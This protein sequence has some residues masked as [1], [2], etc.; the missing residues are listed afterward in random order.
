VVL[1][2]NGSIVAEVRKLGGESAKLRRGWGRLQ[3]HLSRQALGR[4]L[5]EKSKK[6]DKHT[7]IHE[8]GHAVAHCRLNIQQAYVSIDREEIYDEEGNLLAVKRGRAIAEG[9]EHVCDQVQAGDQVLAYYAGFAALLAGGYSEKEAVLGADDDFA[10]ADYLIDFW[11]IGKDYEWKQKA[12][13][14]M[15]DE[16]NVAAV[17]R[18]SEELLRERRLVMDQ[19]ETLIDVADGGIP[20]REYQRVKKAF[21][22][23]RR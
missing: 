4:Q 8:A 22:S 16:S 2:L 20:E 6:Q 5:V 21:W 10:L 23:R 9:I 12:V 3:S 15:Q 14:L 11:Q 18:V 7:A 13:L 17:A 1:E 19:V